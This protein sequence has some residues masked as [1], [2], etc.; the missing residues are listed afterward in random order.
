M[1]LSYQQE[2]YWFLSNQAQSNVLVCYFLDNKIGIELHF[3]CIYDGMNATV[4][5]IFYGALYLEYVID[6]GI[7]VSINATKVKFNPYIDIRI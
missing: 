1:T 7:H 4:N 5:Y 6:G 2:A 3:G